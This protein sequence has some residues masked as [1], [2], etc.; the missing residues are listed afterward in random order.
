MSIHTYMHIYADTMYI[1]PI[2]RDLIATR[3]FSIMDLNWNY[4]K[5]YGRAHVLCYCISVMTTHLHMLLFSIW[6][7][8]SRHAVRCQEL[9]IVNR[10]YLVFLVILL[11][12]NT[13]SIDKIL[14]AFNKTGYSHITYPYSL[15]SHSLVTHS[16]SIMTIPIII[17]IIIMEIYIYTYI[18][19]WTSIASRMTSHHFDLPTVNNSPLLF[20]F[21]FF[22]LAVLCTCD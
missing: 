17:T 4:T 5:L 8:D 15:V 14:A 12:L 21:T 18:P 10:I 13:S 11:T 19:V 20:Y 16:H 7:V 22:Y 9:K 1:V 3:Y 2:K 6:T